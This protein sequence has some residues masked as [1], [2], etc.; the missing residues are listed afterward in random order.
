MIRQSN[1]QKSPASLAFTLIELLVVISIISLLISILLPALGKAKAAAMQIKCANNLKQVAIAWMVYEGDFDAYLPARVKAAASTQS[2][3][4]WPRILA[5]HADIKDPYDYDKPGNIL[6]CPSKRLNSN[7]PY[8]SKTYG[9]NGF[10]GFIDQ[11]G[12]GNSDYVHHSDAVHKPSK[13]YL[14]M[15][16]N[17]FANDSHWSWG[18]YPISA[19]NRITDT[20]AHSGGAAM[21]Y[22]D[23]HVTVNREVDDLLSTTD[24]YKDRWYFIAY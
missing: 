7:V 12:K 4:W 16:A 24:E 18:T 8:L 9:M 3:D 13:T 1:P 10:S 11:Y 6:I 15:D 2:H 22:V 17:R 20:L 5:K 21:S 19:S 23:G 14:N